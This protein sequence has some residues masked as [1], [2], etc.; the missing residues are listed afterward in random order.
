M[1]RGHSSVVIGDAEEDVAVAATPSAAAADVEMGIPPLMTQSTVAGTHD[2][3]T[4]NKPLR[5]REVKLFE[6]WR[7]E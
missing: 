6:N 5:P 3:V 2:N 7:H 1:F 4:P